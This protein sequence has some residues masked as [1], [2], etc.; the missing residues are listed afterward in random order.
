[1]SSDDYTGAPFYI[2][3]LY[4]SLRNNPNKDALQTAKDN[5]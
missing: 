2:G 4:I 3:W 1:M 5:L